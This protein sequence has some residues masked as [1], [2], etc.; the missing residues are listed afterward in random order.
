MLKN[1]FKVAIRNL[2]RQKGYSLINISG[3][4]IGI[5]SAILIILFVS[6]ELSYDRHHEKADQIYRVGLAGRIAN[7]EMEV[8]LSC[9]PIGAALVS[10]YPEVI[11]STRIYAFSG[12]PI[13]RY[14]EKSFVENQFI[15]VDSTF[16]DVFTIPFIRGNPE[17]ALNR[18]NTLVLTKSIANKYFGDENPVGKSLEAGNERTNYEITG[19]VEDYPENSHFHFDLLAS[20]VSHPYSQ[21]DMWISNNN[22]TYILLQE[23]ILPEQLTAKFPEMITKYIGPALQTFMGVSLE[24]FLSGGNKWGYFLQPVTDI[25]LHSNLGYE[26]EANGSNTIVYIFSIIAFFLIIIACINF[27]NLA[28]ARSANRA[29]EVGLRKVVG[30][31]KLLL[32]RQFLSE[33][34]LLSFISLVIAII[35]VEIFLPYFNNLSGKHLDINYLV[36]WFFLPI[37]IGLGLFVGLLAGSYPAFY[38]SRFQPVKV[39]RGMLPSGMK[40]SR[41]RGVLV[42]FQFTITIILFIS[43]FV[44]SKQMSYIRKKDLGFDKENLVIIKRAYALSQQGQAFIQELLKNPDVTSA[45]ISNTIPGELFGNTAFYPEGT[46]V[47][48]THAINYMASD[49]DFA[50]TFGLEITRG[51]FFSKDLASDSM[52]VVLNTAAIKSLGFTNPIDTI[53]YQISGTPGQDVPLKVIGVLKDFHYESL[54]QKIRPLVILLNE[55]ALNY[56]TSRI[57]SANK[58]ETMGFL[59]EKWEEFVDQPFDYSF[60]ENDLAAHYN[61]DKRTGSIFGIFSILAIF[62]ASIGLLGLASFMAEQR[63]KEIGIRKALGASIPGILK[64]LSREIIILIL[65]STPIAWLVAWFYMKDWLQDFA[66]RINI[67][68]LTLIISSLLAFIIALLTV[69]YQAIK[70]ANSNPA[71]SLRYE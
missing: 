69:S 44:V 41:L 62:V 39:L 22:Y 21:N 11:T 17:T 40:S 70:A 71:D 53:L 7:N 49:H 47:E 2:T 18:P 24:E 67:G 38:L 14:E 35:L 68:V 27:M 61:D 52:A 65:I 58:S 34:V 20:F 19:V 3:L 60:L 10:D 59:K 50:K 64:L 15:Y 54:H 12:D 46:G 5:A 29:K 23:G 25:H 37:L 48:G 9:A 33:S 57:N 13:I 6:D 63:T 16:F 55:N 43:T 32:I 42:I 1:Y 8:A 51:R 26:L 56:I 31:S 36:S 4:A 66:Y 30:S 45:T 28:T